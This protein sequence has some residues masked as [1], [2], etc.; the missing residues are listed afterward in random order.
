MGVRGLHQVFLLNTGLEREGLHLKLTGDCGRAL[1]TI[2]E[3]IKVSGNTSPE[4]R[5]ERRAERV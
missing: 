4:Q 3:N 2:R 5:E 1:I